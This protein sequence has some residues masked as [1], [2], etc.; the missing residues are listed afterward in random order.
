MDELLTFAY[1][2]D[3]AP[4]Y[5]LTPFDDSDASLPIAVT[6]NVAVSDNDELARWLRGEQPLPGSDSRQFFTA[7]LQQMPTLDSAQLVD[8]LK[9]AV[10]QDRAKELTSQ[11]NASAATIAAEADAKV[12][13]LI[14]DI[15]AALATGGSVEDVLAVLRSESAK[16]KQAHQTA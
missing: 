1:V 2:L 8:E 14:A 9:R 13:S 12:Q 16:L 7:S 3:I 15:G 6:G 10:L 11:L 5:L 4:I